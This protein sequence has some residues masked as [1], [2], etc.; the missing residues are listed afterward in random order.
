MLTASSKYALRALIC[1]AKCPDD[2]AFIRVDQ[3]SKEAEIP[4]PYLSKIMKIL[5][6]KE[7]VETRRGLTG[8][9]R[10]KRQKKAIS[11]FDVCEALNEPIVSEVCLLSKTSCEEKN[12]C[13]LHREW[14]KNREQVHRFLK[15]A[16]IAPSK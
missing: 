2:G 1:L 13:P 8:G 3:L 6:Q 5:S 7:L 16:R 9:V 12:P 11:F 14:K 15:K 10:L 4:A